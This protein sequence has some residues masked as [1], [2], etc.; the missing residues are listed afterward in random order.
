MVEGSLEFGGEFS[1]DLGVASGS[2]H[3]M[4]G[5]YFKLAGTS[6]TI[7]G[8]VDIGGEVSVLGIISVSIDLNLSLSYQTSNGKSM[9]QGR[10]TLTIGVHIIFFSISVSVSVERSFGSDS[11]DP[12]VDQ[13]LTAQDWSDYAAAYAA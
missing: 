7:T 12:R 2:V 5:I 3:A 9:V 11:G 10:A 6:S 8:F 1:I 4:A 13:L